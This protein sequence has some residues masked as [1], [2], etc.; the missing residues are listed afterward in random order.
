TA[1]DSATATSAPG[2]CV[3]NAG[4]SN[5]GTYGTFKFDATKP[6]VNV[7]PNR[8][9]D[10]NGWYN[11]ALDFTTGC[12]DTTSGVDASGTLNPATYTAPDSATATSAPGTCVDNAGNSNTG[13][14]GTF[15][16]DATKPVVNVTPNRVADHNGWYNA[17]LDFTTGCSDT[18]SGVDASGTLNPATYTAPDSA[19]ATSAP[20]TCVD[21]A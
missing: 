17:A 4:N 7:T 8:V 6:T 12:S 14:Y 5:T 20:G 1:P 18:T 11:A 13:T 19:T 21:N 10:H 15:K 9:A 2:T 16:F 3:D